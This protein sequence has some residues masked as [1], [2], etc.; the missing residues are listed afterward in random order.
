MPTTTSYRFS[1]SGVS[2]TNLS[3]GAGQRV[4]QS[5]IGNFSR[6]D[7][8]WGLDTNGYIEAALTGNGYLGSN[9]DWRGLEIT[10]DND[11]LRVGGW[12]AAAPGGIT[13]DAYDRNGN[14]VESASF[15]SGTAATWQDNFFGLEQANG[16]KRIK[17][18]GSYV[19]LDD[20]VFEGGSTPPPAASIAGAGKLEG[21]GGS[22]TLFLTINLSAASAQVVTV[23][24]ATSNGTASAGSDYLSSAGQI[25]FLP[26]ETSKAIGVSV[27]G[28]VEFEPDE[29]F[30]VVLSNPVGA[31][32]ATATATGTITND[33]AAPPPPVSVGIAGISQNE[34]NGGSSSL[35]D[36]V[37]SLSAASAQTVT[38]NYATSNG[39]AIAGS[40]YT[41]VGGF[42]S[43]AAGETSKIISISVLG[44]GIVEPDESFSVILSNAI[45]ASISNGSAIGTILNDDVAAPPPSISIIALNPQQYE[46]NAGL[47]PYYFTVNL[48]A[49]SS[50]VV[51]VSYTSLNSS[52]TN[53]DGD[54]TGASGILTFNAGETS[55]GI[56]INV[57]GDRRIEG[58]ESFVMGI[59][60]ASGANIGTT[61]ATATILNDDQREVKSD[62]TGDRRSDLVWRN[63]NSGQNL[64]WGSA[65]GGQS[66]ALP[67]VGGTWRISTTGDFNAD[68]Q[69]DLVWRDYATGQAVIWLM[70]GTILSQGIALTTIGMEWQI[71]GSGDFNA[72]GQSDLVWRNYSTGEN[73]IW[74]MNGTALGSIVSLSSVPTE[75]RI[76]GVADFTGDNQPDLVW[77][78]Y[79]TGEVYVW[80]MAGTTYQGS[81]LLT[82]LNDANWHISAVGDYNGDGQNDLVWR[83]FA[84]GETYLWRM[85]GTGVQGIDSLGVIGLDWELT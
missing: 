83:N 49:A 20:F 32:I 68:G 14:L 25:T 9:N 84:T 73:A 42:V 30:S 85:D 37:V 60:N 55:K 81:I 21:D 41:A 24:Y 70:N 78:N 13:M 82:T 61:S 8:G 63:L 74:L 39:S 50:Q 23:N 56:T 72:D 52:A 40:D 35:F 76:D 79:N 51:S 11:A 34:G 33:D 53:S 16:I 64:I 58:D 31:T 7:A 43:F 75:W 28:D 67:T 6:G 47:T 46:G 29:S 19:C 48:S 1:G 66:A 27:L 17:I 15:G 36:F 44:D 45:N 77:R 38:L 10:L 80:Q 2:L 54:Y 26:G 57:N 22:S 69:A 71:E 18:T 62:F 5:V 4:I 59:F 3:S 65:Q 12:F